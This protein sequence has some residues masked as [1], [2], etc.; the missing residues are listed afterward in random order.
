MKLKIPPVIIFFISVAMMFGAYYVMPEW[1]YSFSYQTGISRIFL[2]AGVLVAFS[3]IIIFR[4][5]RT[6]TDPM[7]PDKASAL[8]T[9][10]IYQYT[11]NPMYLGMALILVGGLIRIGNPL[12]SFGLIFLVFYLDRFQIRQEEEVLSKLFGSRYEEYC[13]RVRR[14]I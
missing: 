11:R 13:K 9:A 8:V 3:G 4:M 1:S 12:S 7:H 14:W 10:G 2:A 6:T 5:N